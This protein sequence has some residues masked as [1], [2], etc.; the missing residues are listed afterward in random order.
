MKLK[1]KALA[2]LRS[3]KVP[4]P[5]LQY[6]GSGIEGEAF[7]FN[8]RNKTKYILKVFHEGKKTGHERLFDPL[9]SNHIRY[10]K[11]LSK[12]NLIPKIYKITPYYYIQKYVSGV[13]L[14]EFLGGSDKK[15][16]NKKIPTRTQNEK[17]K[18]YKEIEKLVTKWHKLGFYN[19]DL[20]TQNIIITKIGEKS[21]PKVY[22]I[23]P[24]VP[25]SRL[26]LTKS[27]VNLRQDEDARDLRNIKF[28]LGVSRSSRSRIRQYD[29][30]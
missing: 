30:K 1:S 7:A 27:T 4:D 9:S 5:N 10:I 23:D 18:V 14:D 26:G 19:A 21:G 22:F 20:H 15:S 17:I 29:K 25:C 12:N 11:E 3:L 16:L 6:L 13:T 24:Y 28:D 2:I 8:G